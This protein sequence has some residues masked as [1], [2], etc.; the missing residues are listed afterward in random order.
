MSDKENIIQKNDKKII[1]LVEDDKNTSILIQ[2]ILDVNNFQCI[3]RGDGKEALETLKTVT[4]DLILMDVMMPVMDGV[5]ATKIIKKDERLQ[6]IPIIFFTAQDDEKLIK[7]FF[8]LGIVDYISKPFKNLELVARIK[9]AI[10]IK[11]EK[12][13]L[14][15]NTEDLQNLA[16]TVIEKSEELEKQNEKLKEIDEVKDTFITCITHDFKTPITSIRALTEL[17]I[18][19][20]GLTAPKRKEFLKTVLQQVDNLSEMVTS[21]LDSFKKVTQSLELHKIDISLKILSLEVYNGFKPIADSKGIDFIY[22][23]V[24]EFEKIYCDP[25][26]LKEVLQNLLS[27]AFKFTEKGFVSFSV[28]ETNNYICFEIVDSGIG[29]HPDDIDKVFEKFYRVKKTANL[30]EGSGLGLFIAKK[31]VLSHKG[32]ILVESSF[33]NGTKFTVLLPKFPDR[34]K[35]DP[36]DFEL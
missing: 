2:K 10:K 16:H 1:L 30:R 34:S 4:P 12:N 35:N 6:N 11:D 15:K 24:T 5:K 8:N 28:Y 13:D 18:D 19:N 26:K 23:F 36:S 14:I 3:R 32:D 9:S 33:G 29:I 20:Q 31:I 21:L 7:E 17:M 22:K 25:I 27:N